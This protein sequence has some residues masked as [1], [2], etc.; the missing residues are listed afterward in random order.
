MW[1]SSQRVQLS[2]PVDGKRPAKARALAPRPRNSLVRQ[3]RRRSER[4]LKGCRLTLA[5]EPG[6]EVDVVGLKDTVPLPSAGE[7]TSPGG[8][9]LQ[10]DQG[11]APFSNYFLGVHVEIARCL[12]RTLSKA[13]SGTTAAGAASDQARCS[14]PRGWR[15]GRAVNTDS[16]ACRARKVERN[17]WRDTGCFSPS[18]DAVREMSICQAMG[19]RHVCC[20]TAACTR[21]QPQ[22]GIA[23]CPTRRLL[24]AMP[25]SP[26]TR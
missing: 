25:R 7:C 13:P 4:D 26:M 15:P 21:H 8:S 22:R 10:R 12:K 1:R 14:E 18:H 9:A 3:T 23:R 11:T 16:H 5:K 6:P 17:V 24:A 20:V 2:G 19:H